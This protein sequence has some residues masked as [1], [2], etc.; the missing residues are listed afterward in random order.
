M[1]CK[2]KDLNVVRENDPSTIPHD[3]FLAFDNGVT[4]ALAV[5]N[6]VDS[7]YSFTLS[8]DYVKK[9]LSYT[10]EKK[11]IT[12]ID[13]NKLI[14]LIQN[15]IIHC[16]NPIAIVER[17]MINPKRFIASCS[18]L[19]SL[20]ATLIALE[21]FCIPVV[22]CD[23]KEW[24]HKLFG[25]T[26]IGDTKDRS[27]ELGLTLFPQFTDKINKQDADAL[28]ILKWFVEKQKGKIHHG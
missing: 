27:R 15:S 4:G 2:R 14:L 13:F 17:P 10:K 25:K 7:T 12:R 3:C 19:R 6:T 28:L 8:K 1:P 11:N 9:E 5:C 23:S 21:Y 18:A 22:Y 26:I 24:Q 16:R 20:E